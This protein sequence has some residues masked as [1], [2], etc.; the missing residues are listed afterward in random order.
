MYVASTLLQLR[1]T[2]HVRS[3]DVTLDHETLTDGQ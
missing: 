3:T 2:W 1:A